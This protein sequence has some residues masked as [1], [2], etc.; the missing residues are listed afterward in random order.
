MKKYLFLILICFQFQNSF[1]MENYPK[2]VLNLVNKERVKK[3]LKVLKLNRTLNKISINK[4]NDMS[5]AKYFGHNSKKYGSPFDM[6]KKEGI[7]YRTAGENIAKGQKTSSYVVE[8]WMESKGHKDNILNPNFTEMGIGKD[9]FNEN[10]W[11]Q[12]FIGN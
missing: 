9:S 11:T 8:T 2:E 12:I 10:I 4:S 5:K 7:K 1:S 6:I 3:N